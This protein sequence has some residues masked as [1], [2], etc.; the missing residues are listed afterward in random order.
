MKDATPG[1]LQWLADELPRLLE[2]GAWEK[3]EDDRFVCRAFLVPKPGTNKW[4]L[5]VDLRFLNQFIA[6][7]S[8]KFETLRHL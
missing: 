3:T 5:I 2:K 1:Q 6:G 7:S 8:M 4:R